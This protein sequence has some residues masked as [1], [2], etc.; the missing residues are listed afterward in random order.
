M[1]WWLFAEVP[2]NRQHPITIL[3]DSFAATIRALQ[4]GERRPPSQQ[5][6]VLRLQH[7]YVVGEISLTSLEIEL[8]HL[9]GG[10][11]PIEDT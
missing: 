5:E 10:L 11:P 1:V 9:P 7:A 6:K 2:P 8:D 3:G 4:G